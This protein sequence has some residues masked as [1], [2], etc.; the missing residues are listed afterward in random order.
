MI[1]DRYGDS[2]YEYQDAVELYGEDVAEL[3]WSSLKNVCAPRIL[4]EEGGTPRRDPDGRMAGWDD[5][6]TADHWLHLADY[7]PDAEEQLMYM[8]MVA[9]KDRERQED[10]DRYPDD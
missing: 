1:Q 8:D 9:R 5:P 4:V 2:W 3:A 10:R 6:I 7:I